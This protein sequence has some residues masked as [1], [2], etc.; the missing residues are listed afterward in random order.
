[1]WWLN[2]SGL[3]KS[4]W[5]HPDSANVSSNA[6]AVFAMNSTST[7]TSGSCALIVSAILALRGPPPCWMFQT[8]I[9]ITGTAT[10]YQAVEERCR[11]QRSS[12][13]R[14]MDCG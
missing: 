10:A 6:V 3:A 12:Y 7:T 9:F 8:R 1:M 2:P 5:V 4:R 11:K 14:V 13:G